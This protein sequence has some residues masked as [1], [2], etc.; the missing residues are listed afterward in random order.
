MV[1]RPARLRPPWLLW[2]LAVVA[3]LPYL[4]ALTAD[5]TFDDHLVIRRNPAVTTGVDLGRVFTTPLIKGDLYRPLTILSFALNEAASPGRPG[6]YHLVNVGLHVAVT[7]LVFFVGRRLFDAE[8]IAATAAVLFAVH[9]IHTEA[10][11]SLVGRSELFV[12]LFGLLTL[13][14]SVRRDAAAGTGTRAALLA[15][16]LTAFACALLSKE[17]AVMLLV[18]LPLFR[19]AAR[20]E[21]FRAGLWTELCSLEWVPYAL[22]VGT[23]LLLRSCVLAAYTP[24]TIT[25]LDNILRFVPWT[26]RLPSA[27]A[28]LWDYF[29]LLNVPF[30]L[31]ADYSYNQVPVTGWLSWR[32]LAGTALLVTAAGIVIRNR[33]PAVSFAV[34]LP[35]VT[36]ALTSN[37]FVL[38]GTVKAE[39]HLYLPSVGWALLAAYALERARCVPRYRAVVPVALAVTVSAFA[40]RTWVRNWDW[41]D[42]LALYRSMVRTAPESAKAHFNYGAML[43]ERAAQ[44]AAAVQFRRALEIY[45]V[46]EAAVGMGIEAESRRATDE[47]V[48]WYG[49]ALRMR[50][51]LSTAHVNL[52]YLL[53]RS[54]RWQAAATACRNGLRYDPINPKLLKALGTSWV[55]LGATA[56]GVDLMRRA[57]ALDGDDD[58]LRADIA[59][60]ETAA[61]SARD[62]P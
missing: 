15:A 19:V 21:P 5:F 16:S 9:P 13:L 1:S 51:N 55:E 18:L 11:T 12:A 46:A 38:I 35:L 23:Y 34:L 48:E 25:S 43:Q 60:W 10:V 61:A 52:C 14:A 44:A 54:A 32:A 45:P 8:W 42:D 4:N 57:L 29:G 6:P 59:R 7:I 40:V 2:L 31:A 58:A 22:C 62:R 30:V 33:R 20:G 27:L 24:Y 53:L 36:V 50:P 26:E 56:H 37:L 17:S 41:A 3:A 28:V 47:A 49:Q 39:R